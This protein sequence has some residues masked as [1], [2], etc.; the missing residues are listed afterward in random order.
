MDDIYI[1][2]FDPEEIIMKFLE[3]IQLQLSIRND[4]PLIHG[5]MLGSTTMPKNV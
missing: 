1:Q 2:N 4:I 3:M 5:K